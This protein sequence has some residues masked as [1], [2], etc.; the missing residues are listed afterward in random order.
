MH[1]FHLA[2][3]IYKTIMDYGQK[4]GLKKITKAEIELGSLVEHGEE[5]LPANLDFNIKMLA[6]G[7][8]ADGLEISIKRTVGNSWTLKNIEGDK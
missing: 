1:D 8:I 7:G 4:N 6:E 2:D 3:Q 5:I